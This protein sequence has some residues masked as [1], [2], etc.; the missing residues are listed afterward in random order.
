VEDAHHDE[1]V[2]DVVDGVPQDLD[3]RPRFNRREE[4]VNNEGVK[5]WACV[6]AAVLPGVIGWN[7][8][9]GAVV[10]SQP[11]EV[12][13]EAGYLEAGECRARRDPARVG[14]GW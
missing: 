8:S 14:G 5:L 7:G 11:S 12:G 6:A 3:P 1:L 10:V 13:V 2:R 4:A 9:L